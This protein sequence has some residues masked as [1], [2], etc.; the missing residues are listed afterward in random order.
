MRSS[1]LALVCLLVASAASGQT[2]THYN[3]HRRG[4]T[5]S[6][7]QV[8]CTVGGTD[9]VLADDIDGS[10]DYDRLSVLIK[11][12]DGVGNSNVF[13]CPGDA[14]CSAAEGF[15]LA[16]GEGMWLDWS[17]GGAIGCIGSGGTATVCY[18]EERG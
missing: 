14:T 5:I 1:F 15:M 4:D 16:P 13:I 9:V 10:G 3:R 2:S 17:N 8:S 6:F 11:N 7:N 18:I 12:C